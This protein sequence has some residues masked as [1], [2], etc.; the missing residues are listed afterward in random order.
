MRECKTYRTTGLSSAIRILFTAVGESTGMFASKGADAEGN[1]VDAICS[2]QYGCSCMVHQ[3]IRANG[4]R[5]CH[6]QAFPTACL[7]MARG[8]DAHAAPCGRCVGRT[9]RSGC[10]TKTK[11]DL[12]PAPLPRRLPS[13]CWTES[14]AS[15]VVEMRDNARVTLNLP[16]AAH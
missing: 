10:A 8:G 14:V 6:R 4:R 11:G 3:A 1:P 7:G 2:K 15:G 12:G 16:Y 5:H 9:A 13:A